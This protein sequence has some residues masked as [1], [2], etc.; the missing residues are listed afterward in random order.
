MIG[1]GLADELDTRDVL[2]DNEASLGQD[3]AIIGGA[4]GPNE[5]ADLYASRFVQVVDSFQNDPALADE[6]I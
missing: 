2:N 5:R 1:I 4:S 3:G 6:G